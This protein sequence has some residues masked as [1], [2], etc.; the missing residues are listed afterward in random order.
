LSAAALLLVS[1]LPSRDR[2]MLMA[3]LITRGL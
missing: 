2:L 1:A 3:E